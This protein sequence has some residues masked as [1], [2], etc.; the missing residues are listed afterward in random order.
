MKARVVYCLLFSKGIFKAF[1]WY[2]IIPICAAS[3]QAVLLAA[4]K[5]SWTERAFAEPATLVR[6]LA[7][8]HVPAWQLWG[9]SHFCLKDC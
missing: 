5:C 7:A 9:R 6:S 2:E 1:L 8:C 4:L 3:Q